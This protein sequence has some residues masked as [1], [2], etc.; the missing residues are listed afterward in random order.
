[1]AGQAAQFVG[2]GKQ[3]QSRCQRPPRFGATAVLAASPLP[4][5]WRK[6]AWFG[7]PLPAVCVEFRPIRLENCK[8]GEGALYITSAV[9]R[10][11]E[12]AANACARTH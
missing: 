6:H 8:G 11:R 12:P 4:F 2:R 7:I 1:M 5:V 10:V 9:R 3:A